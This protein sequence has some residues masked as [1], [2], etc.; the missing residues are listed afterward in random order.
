[1]KKGN[2]KQEKEEKYFFKL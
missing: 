1:M 2:S